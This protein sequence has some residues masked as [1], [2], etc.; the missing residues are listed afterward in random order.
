MQ[1]ALKS[2]MSGDRQ[3]LPQ[4]KKSDFHAG[5]NAEDTISML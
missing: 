5:P 2:Y 1:N 3:T 4:E